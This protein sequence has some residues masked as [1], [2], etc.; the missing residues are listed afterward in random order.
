MPRILCQPSGTHKDRWKRTYCHLEAKSAVGVN[1]ETQPKVLS[2]KGGFLESVIMVTIYLQLSPIEGFLHQIPMQR[3]RNRKLSSQFGMVLLLVTRNNHPIN[4]MH[5]L[6]SPWV[7]SYCITSHSSNSARI[8][9]VPW[10]QEC[11]AAT[12]S[13]EAV[14]EFYR[15]PSRG[16]LFPQSCCRILDLS[17]IKICPRGVKRRT[18]G[19]WQPSICLAQRKYLAS[20]CWE[21]I[22]A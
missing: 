16:N 17:Q 13:G 22:L 2:P 19:D 10:H 4:T 1:I 6:T 3:Q 7:A 20:T 5:F 15:F 9:T 11:P 12:F 18:V 14:L 21:V 8:L